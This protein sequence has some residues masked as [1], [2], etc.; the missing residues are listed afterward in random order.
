MWVRG[1][2]FVRACSRAHVRA[3]IQRLVRDLHLRGI[4][5]EGGIP[6]Y[7]RH[8]ATITGVLLIAAS[9]AWLSRVSRSSLWWAYEIY[10][11]LLWYGG[12][13]LG[14][15]IYVGVIVALLKALWDRR[16]DDFA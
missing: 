16:H 10:L 8:K 4:S 7:Y 15:S 3:R 6:W 5:V 13:A 2:M 11:S 9:C 1:R 14:A 12:I